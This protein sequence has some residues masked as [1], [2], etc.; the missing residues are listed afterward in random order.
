MLSPSSLSPTDD[1][2]STTLR[3]FLS[4]N[5]NT[6]TE[7]TQGPYPSEITSLNGRRSPAL[8]RV[9][10]PSLNLST[11][12]R[13]SATTTTSNSNLQNTLPARTIRPRASMA[14]MSRYDEHGNRRSTPTSS[15]VLDKER[16]KERERRVRTLGMTDST[17][18]SGGRSSPS[19]TISD[20]GDDGRW[21]SRNGSVAGGSG[22]KDLA[23]VERSS[24][25][26]SSARRKSDWLDKEY[27]RSRGTPTRES[28]TVREESYAA[29]RLR[30]E[31]EA[32]NNNSEESRRRERAI[33]PSMSINEEGIRKSPALARHRPSLPLEFI[34]STSP[35]MDR[36]KT[37]SPRIQPSSLS[38][39]IANSVLS[40]SI[41]S[42]TT[43]ITAVSTRRGAT[44]DSGARRY[45][46]Q[47]DGTPTSQNRPL[48][49]PASLGV[50]S[51]FDGDLQEPLDQRTLSRAR[52]SA[53]LRSQMTEAQLAET[54][55]VEKEDGMLFF[56]SF[57]VLWS[58]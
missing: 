15:T 40:S 48:P 35:R 34:S 44:P 36:E 5:D 46:S 7:P 29:R 45:G 53:R 10:S 21:S 6:P 23:G 30:A 37:L 42:R 18:G 52:S 43:P 57:S 54:S 11:S 27:E 2:T 24:T 38:P 8:H 56:F 55:R 3:N 41:S 19:N 1:L 31:A 58:Y 49:P 51:R 12:S 13:T 26:M 50:P 22:R 4:S 47:T 9:P 14:D 39:R 16:D 33:S 28:G 20:M 25:S 32:S 17:T